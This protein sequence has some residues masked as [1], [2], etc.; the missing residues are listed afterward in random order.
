MENKSKIIEAKAHVKTQRISA[1]KARLVAALIKNRSTTDA[2]AILH[3]TNK[4]AAYFFIKLVNSAVANAVN[5]FGLS[6][7]NLYVKQAIVNEGTTLKR[8]QPKSKG[9]AA[10]IYKRTSHLSVFVV[11]RSNVEQGDL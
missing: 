8:Y 6:G 3:N 11:E 1:Q 9:V 7:T 5:N 4:K 2:L 10:S